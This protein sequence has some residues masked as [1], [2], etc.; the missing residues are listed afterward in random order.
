M[1][2]W[3]STLNT[4]CTNGLICTWYIPYLE[5]GM[6][7]WNGR[8]WEV[9]KAKGRIVGPERNM[10]QC[11]EVNRSSLICKR[12]VK[13][14]SSC[15]ETNNYHCFRVS[16]SCK[17]DFNASRLPSLMFW[18]WPINES[19]WAEACFSNSPVYISD[20]KLVWPCS[21]WC[22]HGYC[23]KILISISFSTL[24]PLYRVHIVC[25]NQ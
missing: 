25:I 10:Q 23:F 18:D 11:G 6:R 16:P 22:G 14:N 20:I 2:I 13:I 8:D 9:G 7:W 21:L 12:G 5:C 24:D 15:P 4:I 3:W 17:V 1:L 19:E